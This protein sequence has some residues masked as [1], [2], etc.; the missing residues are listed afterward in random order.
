[1]DHVGWKTTSSACHYIKLGRV[2]HPGSVGDS[3][4]GLSMDVAEL[5][6][7]QMSLLFTPRPF[8]FYFVFLTKVVLLSL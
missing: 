3:L 2:E 8:D 5:H 7:K 1:M 6:R 4:A